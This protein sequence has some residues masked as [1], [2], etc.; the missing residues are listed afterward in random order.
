MAIFWMSLK[1][2]G[3]SGSKLNS[4]SLFY[5][6]NNVVVS[7]LLTMLLMSPVGVAEEDGELE[8]Q[9]PCNN[10]DLENQAPS[11]EV[12]TYPSDRIGRKRRREG[13]VSELCHQLANFF[14]TH[15]LNAA[16]SLHITRQSAMQPTAGCI[17]HVARC[18]QGSRSQAQGCCE[19]VNNNIHITVVFSFIY[20]SHTFL[21][22]WFSLPP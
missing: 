6:S 12:F 11:G 4:Y 15:D 8:N 14:T 16:L 17:P 2:K 1:F 13:S 7:P 21:S 20:L 10:E 22:H 19:R 5:R 18:P 3:L 9:A